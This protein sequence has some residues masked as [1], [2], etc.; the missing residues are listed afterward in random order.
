MKEERER[1][2]A[3]LEELQ[4]QHDSQMEE[5]SRLQRRLDDS[6]GELRKNLEE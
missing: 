3:N 4:G 6:E 5:N 2:R 1:M